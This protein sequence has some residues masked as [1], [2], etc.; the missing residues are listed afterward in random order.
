MSVEAVAIDTGALERLV[1]QVRGVHAV[2]VV[3]LHG[4]Q[5]DEVHVV[6]TPRRSPKAIVRDIE[7]IVLVRGGIKLDHR[8]VSLVQVDDAAINVATPRVRIQDVRQISAAEST[9]VN[10]LLSLRDL[11]VTG[12]GSSRPEQPA[13]LPL[14]AAYATI[15]A[16]NSLLG[17][18]TSI[19]LERLQRQ[20]FGGGEVY[21]V[22]LSRAYDDAVE[23]LLGISVVRDDELSAVVRAVLDAANRA[24]E[25]AISEHPQLRVP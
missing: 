1:S 2:R 25:R 8:K 6:G 24:V 17:A 20:P 15:H 11:Q 18:Q 5:I 7:S 16:L 22:Q 23:Q 14:L 3:S 12:V 9:S 10:V 4:D 13:D 19:Q 21:L